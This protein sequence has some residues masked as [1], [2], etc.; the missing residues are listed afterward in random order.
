V[1][2]ATVRADDQASPWDEIGPKKA[3]YHPPSVRRRMVL[4]F[5]TNEVEAEGWAPIHDVLCEDAVRPVR[6][7]V[8]GESGQRVDQVDAVWFDPIPL[9]GGPCGEA[10]HQQSV[11][12]AHVQESPIP[13]Y[14]RDDG[15]SGSF[16]AGLITP[17]PRSCAWITSFEVSLLEQG[18]GLFVVSV[19]FVRQF[20][21]P[22][23]A[24]ALEAACTSLQHTAHLPGCRRDNCCSNPECST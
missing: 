12:A 10:L 3:F 14:R 8:P 21:P 5:G 17:K 9:F 13:V 7:S 23:L 16:P 24:G 20:C 6:E 22:T 19:I 18:A 11:C 4:Q 1:A 2:G 15:T